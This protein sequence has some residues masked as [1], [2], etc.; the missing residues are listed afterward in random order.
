MIK[1]LILP[2]EPFQ[3]MDDGVNVQFAGTDAD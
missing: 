3:H 2:A 1:R